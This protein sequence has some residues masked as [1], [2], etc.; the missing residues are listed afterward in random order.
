[1]LNTY[2]TNI[3]T[4]VCPIT[5]VVEKTITPDK[6]TEMYDSV[7]EQVEKDI[8]RTIIINN[9]T[10]NGVIFEKRDDFAGAQTKILYRFTLNGI[11]YIERDFVINREDN[12]EERMINKFH[13]YVKEKIAI[14]IIKENIKTII[15]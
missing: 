7:R 9:N 2:K 1:M 4:T 5:Q 14:K 3:E 15:K 11:E 10:L 8:L 6:V 13:D 12:T